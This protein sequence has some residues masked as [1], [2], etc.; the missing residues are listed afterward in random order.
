[1]ATG[2]VLPA[3]TSYTRL[4]LITYLLFTVCPVVYVCAIP[5]NEWMVQ[6]VGVLNVFSLL[7]LTTAASF[8]V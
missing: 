3:E 6:F 8:Q 2:V 1:M 5:C 7:F 4:V